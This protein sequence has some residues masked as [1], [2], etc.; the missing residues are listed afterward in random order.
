M[1]KPSWKPSGLV[2][3]LTDFGTADPYVGMM[4]GAILSQQPRA[5][6]V[7]LCHG[8]PPQDVRVGAWFLR[9]SLP[10]FPEGTV[11]VVVVDPGVG[12]GRR[13]LVAEDRGLAFLAPDNG[14]LGPVL[15][16][17]ARV[18][19]LDSARFARAGASR[20]FHGRDIL[21][22][23]AAAIAGGLE[24]ARAGVAEV[25][26]LGGVEL[27]RPRRNADGSLESEVVLADRYGNLVLSV[28]A[29]DLEGGPAGWVIESDERTI[30]LRG[31]YAEAASGELLA[32]VD[33]YGAIE[34]AV[35]DGSAA[36][37]LG[38]RPGAT[39]VLRRRA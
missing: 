24:P 7:D 34:I 31:T 5:V 8:V 16:S 18:F 2:T 25:E 14:L 22:P 10:Y 37:R 38:L 15:S 6:I 20:T 21:A 12:S 26:P 9:H 13:L 11:H 27:P 28:G 4:K 39:V 1:T 3:L 30:P 19:E 36:A 17:E 29:E 33:S 23:A 32:V 35:R